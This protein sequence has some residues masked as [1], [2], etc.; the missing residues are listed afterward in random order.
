MAT[1]TAT[2][3]ARDLS[4]E[5]HPLRARI[6]G[7]VF[8]I[9][10]AATFFIFTNGIDPSLTSSFGLNQGAVPRE[11][12][13]PDW[14]I[15]SYG[16]VLVLAIVSAV[17]GGIQ[18]ARGFGKWTT[19][20]LGVVLFFFIFSFLIWATAGASINLAGML[21]T[22]LNAAVPITLAAFS[23]ILCERAG[24]TNIAI[25]GMM[26]GSAMVSTLIASV[27]DS[28]WIGLLAGI[29]TSVLLALIHAVLSIHYK[30]D[31]IIS[32]TVINIFSL[33]L[34]SYIS[35]RF[36]Q[37]F[38]DEL[39]APGTFETWPIPGL[40]DIP[41][42]GRLLFNG[43]LFLYG[44][45]VLLIVIHI[46]LFY[47]RWGL[48]VRA[49]GENPKAADTLGVN[50]FRTRYIS[51]LLG[52]A[53][54]GFAGAYF[55]LGSVGQFD[56]GMTAGRGFIGLAAMIFGN[57]S[58]FGAFGAALI[59]GFADSLQTRLSILQVPIP[60]EFLGMAPYLFTIIALAGLVGR[61]TPPAADG[62]PYEK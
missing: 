8:L 43:N 48:R 4:A 60:S 46:G 28:L 20:A 1:A 25:E 26:L 3:S 32:G 39:N 38:A 47:T 56:E 23:G 6:Y 18:L 50:V 37:V 57:W 27:T 41:I 21:G 19:A 53:L 51:V 11:Q 12:R 17:L 16:S 14:E 45:F 2:A 22:M 40:V 61:A 33:G 58:P 15:P 9:L 49:V 52:G 55:T 34:T 5:A 10:A 35:S 42:I 54:A 36:M 44:M 29:L 62:Q 24:V 31:Q 7:V 13:L 30:I 59:F